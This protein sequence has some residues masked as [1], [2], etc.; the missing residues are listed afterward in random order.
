VRSPH[1]PL[2]ERVWAL[3][4]ELTAYEAAYLALAEALGGSVLLTSHGA[5]AER[6]ASALGRDRVRFAD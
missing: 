2:R 3:R 4:E 1:A 5:L 6:A